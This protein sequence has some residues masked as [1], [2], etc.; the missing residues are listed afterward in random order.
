VLTEAP[1]LVEFIPWT[2]DAFEHQ[3]VV[4]D[5][6]LERPQAPGASTA[7]ATQAREKWQ[8]KGLGRVSTEPAIDGVR[9][10]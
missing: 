3:S 9:Q 4:R 6:F 8:I 10:P 1:P 2:Q 5:G 7:I